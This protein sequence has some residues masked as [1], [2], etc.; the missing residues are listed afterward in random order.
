MRQSVRALARG[1]RGCRRGGR[2]RPLASSRFAQ[3]GGVVQLDPLDHDPSR[4]SRPIRCFWQS[5]LQRSGTCRTRQTCARHLSLCRSAARAR[6][7][8]LRHS[9][10]FRGWC[11]RRARVRCKVIGIAA[12]R[13][14]FDQPRRHAAQCRRPRKLRIALTKSRVWLASISR[15]GDRCSCAWSP[16][17]RRCVGW[18]ACGARTRST[19]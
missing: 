16:D 1:H 11:E 14:C 12:G 13:H 2:V 18:S 15:A 5:H 8:P 7:C 10:G 9:R 3:S 17:S 19:T 4:S 6:Y